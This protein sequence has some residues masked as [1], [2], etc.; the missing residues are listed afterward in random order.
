MRGVGTGLFVKHGLGRAR[1][2]RECNVCVYVC[3]GGEQ[4]C[5]APAGC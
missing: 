4:A 1:K 5:N 3:L 2:R